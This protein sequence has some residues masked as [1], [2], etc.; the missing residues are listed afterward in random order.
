MAY[1]PGIDVSHWQG[2]IQW[3]AVRSAGKYFAFIKVT[4]G[5]NYTDPSFSQNWAGAKAAGILRGAYH[6]FRPLQDA[7]RQAEL[8]CTTVAL[9]DGDLPPVL[10]LE[11]SENLKA[12]TIIQRAELWLA[13]VESRTGRRPIIYSG[14]NFL[15][16]SFQVA[17]GQPPAWVKDYHLWIANY[18]GPGATQPYLPQGWKRWTFWQHSASGQVSGIQGNVDLDW[19]NGSE[20][21]LLALTGGQT[22]SAQQR[23]LVKEG[24]SLEKIAQQFNVT[25]TE[26]VR[27]NP[28]LLTAGMWLNLPRASAPTPSSGSN[29]ENPTRPSGAH[30]PVPV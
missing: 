28:Q 24:D 15:N 17:P 22:Q 14:V 18:L 2:P 30:G 12:A 21:E 3:P 9:E 19:F 25:L 16:T 6:F 4:E 26:L 7:R 5:T 20:Q 13:E 23:Y 27:A 1:L 8:F 29:T 10:D 11:V